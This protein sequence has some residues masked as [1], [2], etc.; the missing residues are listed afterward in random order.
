MHESTSAAD[1]NHSEPTKSGPRPGSFAELW[2]IAWPLM[3]SQGSQSLA[4]V[5]DRM[6]MTQYQVESAAAALPA[7]MLL[8]T[9]SAFF[10]GAVMYVNTFVAQ[11]EG[12]KRPDR[13]LASIWQ[14]VYFAAVGGLLLTACAWLAEPVFRA[15][16]HEAGVQLLEAEY[17][18]ILCLGSIPM[19]VGGALS[20]YFSGRGRP[21]VILWVNVAAS[22]V[23]ILFN[24]LL[25]FGRW[26]FPE[27]GI[28]GAAWST[29][30]GALVAM[31]SYGVLITRDADAR[32]YGWWRSAGFD[33]KLFGRLLKFGSPAG[34]H[35]FIDVVCFSLFVVVVGWM[36]TK[37]L[38]ATNIAFNL[39]TLAF[40]PMIGLGTAVSTLVGQRI[41]EGRPE[42]AVRTTWLAVYGSV[43]YMS[44]FVAFYLLLPDFLLELYKSDGNRADMDAMH[45]TIVLLLRFVALYCVFDAVQIIFGAALRGAGDTHF[46]MVFSATSSFVLMVVPT[47]VSQR[48]FGGGLWEAWATVTVLVLTLA[49]G[50]HLR[51]QQGKWKSMRVIEEAPPHDLEEI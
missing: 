5:F 27:L 19:M 31:L 17:F 3:L 22:A 13:I 44:A 20:C 1:S 45:G 43:A 40:I 39:N 7:G 41:G 36:G 14:G 25:I 9:I 12:A 35:F 10:I 49:V 48:Y 30:M 46:C 15:V 6:F 50:F 38:A 28:A 37:E 29:N 47:Y 21:M 51:F 23:D 16:G 18:S 24:Y 26:G 11:Y 34:F 2:P 32:R 42:L 33:R 4:H 8:W